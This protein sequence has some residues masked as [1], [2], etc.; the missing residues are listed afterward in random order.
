MAGDHLGQR[1]ESY[2]ET[3]VEDGSVC[4]GIRGADQ[5]ADDILGLSGGD[6]ELPIGD[7]ALA[8]C[9]RAVV[10]KECRIGQE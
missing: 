5:R 2:L 10:P 1:E 9:A 7:L 8:E 4:M 3:G 6:L